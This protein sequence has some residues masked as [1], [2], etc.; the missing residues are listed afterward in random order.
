MAI[1]AGILSR[2]LGEDFFTTGI[3]T[4]INRRLAKSVVS[5]ATKDQ[6]KIDL[7]EL[8]RNRGYLV[9]S[10]LD[11]VSNA[12]YKEYSKIVKDDLRSKINY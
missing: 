2:T 5:D 8:R 3:P 12:V 9:E 7:D 6:M 11:D 10:D 1:D 4:V